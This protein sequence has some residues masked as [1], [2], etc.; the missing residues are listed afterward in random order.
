LDV[1]VLDTGVDEGESDAQGKAVRNQEIGLWAGA[2][3]I[4]EIL[5]NNTVSV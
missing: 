2:P 1:F 5:L 4:T 3:S